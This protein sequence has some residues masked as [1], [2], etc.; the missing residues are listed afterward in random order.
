MCVLLLNQTKPSEILPFFEAAAKIA[1]RDCLTNENQELLN[2]ESAT[3]FQII[4]KSSQS[5]QSLRHLTADQ[6]NRLIKV[7]GIVISCS[8]TRAKTTMICLRCTKCQTVKVSAVLLC[9]FASLPATTAED[10]VQKRDGWR[11]VA[12]QL[13]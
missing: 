3:D 9:V 11:A 4:L 5:P 8:K 10:P 2:L 12:Q 6:V 1:L 7:P 13:R